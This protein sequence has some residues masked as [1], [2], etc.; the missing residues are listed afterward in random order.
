M[1][2]VL[3]DTEKHG[4]L[5]HSRERVYHV[6]ILQPVSPITWPSAITCANLVDLIDD[7]PFGTVLPISSRRGT[8]ARR[9]VFA[10]KTM[11]KST[12]LLGAQWSRI[13]CELCSETPWQRFCF[14]CYR[15]VCDGCCLCCGGCGFELCVECLHT[16]RCPGCGAGRRDACGTDEEAA[17]YEEVGQPCDVPLGPSSCPRCRRL[18]Y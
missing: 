4:G 16:T 13:L 2:W 18:S 9:R 7:T 17:L 3:L 11:L 14:G 5:P 6:G 12:G 1:S 15:H 10:A 8:V